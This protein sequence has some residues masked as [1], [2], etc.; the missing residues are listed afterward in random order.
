MKTKREN[1]LKVLF[2]FS[3][4]ARGKMTGS[5]ILA[6]IGEMFGMAPYFVVTLLAKELYEGTATV[7][8]AAV[9]AVTA[10]VFQRMGLGE[11]L[12]T[13]VMGYRA[14]DSEVGALLN[15]GGIVSMLNVSAIICISSSYSGIF[16]ETALLTGVKGLILSI[17]RKIT[18][19]GGIMVTS[20][21]TSMVACN[22]SLAI[23]LTSQLCAEV[24][25]DREQFAIDIENSTVTIAPLVPWSIAGGVPLATI[26]GPTACILFACF[27][28]LLP[29]YTFVCRLVKRSRKIV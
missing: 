26:G 3:G 22:Q 4:E 20:V 6:F 13:A 9:M 18:P 5:V 7:E 25:P 28:Y 21:I 24:E 29:A 19:F 11:I 16:K 2:S 23:M 8:R 10:A 15:G 27:L 17:S 1:P 12:H 14:A